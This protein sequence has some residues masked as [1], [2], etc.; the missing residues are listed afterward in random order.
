MVQTATLLLLEPIFEED[1]L[2]CSYGYRPG[3][4]AHQ[5][6]EEIQGHLKAGYQ[7]VYDADLKAY[8][9]TISHEKLLACLRC[10]ASTTFPSTSALVIRSEPGGTSTGSCNIACRCISNGAVNGRTKRQK[11]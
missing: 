9:D 11:E 6:L 3:R 1:F 8:F 7:V 2:E 5:A 4:K 10:P